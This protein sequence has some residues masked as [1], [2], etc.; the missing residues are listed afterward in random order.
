[1]VASAAP[2]LKPSAERQGLRT[3]LYFRRAEALR[4]Y[5]ASRGDLEVSGWLG[6]GECVPPLAAM[7]L[8]KILAAGLVLGNQRCSSSNAWA[9]EQLYLLE[10]AQVV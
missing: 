2:A 8:Q 9:A 5:R 1:M 3:G 10:F 4:F 7:D 6:W